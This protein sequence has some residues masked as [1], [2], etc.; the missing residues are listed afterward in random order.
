[1]ARISRQKIKTWII[2]GASSGLGKAICK[3]ALNIGYNVIALSRRKSNFDNERAYSLSCDVTNEL[4]VEKAVQEGI[5]YFGGIDVLINNAGVS[6]HYTLEESN[7]KDLHQIFETNFFGTCNITRECLKHFR[8]KG[9]GTIINNTSQS[10]LSGRLFGCGYCSTKH[11]LEGLTS[12]LRLETQKFCRVMAVEYGWFSGTDIGN[13]ATNI[14]TQYPEYQINDE[15]SYLYHSFRNDI[16]IGI[17]HLINQIEQKELPRHL[18]LGCDAIAKIDNEISILKKNLCLSRKR[19]LSCALPH[20]PDKYFLIKYLPFIH[21]KYIQGSVSYSFLYLPLIQLSPY[22]DF[23]IRK[24]IKK[25]LKY[26]LPESFIIYLK[27][28]FITHTR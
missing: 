26:L 6:S 16:T 23:I 12:V 14:P 18:I 8:L 17:N 20:Y 24:N 21:K 5:R 13:M 11:A 2:T 15:F 10:G 3:E 19:S 1:M 27:K 4:S 25:F 9:Y 22:H 7:N 28:Y